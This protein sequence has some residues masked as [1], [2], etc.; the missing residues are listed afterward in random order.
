MVDILD[1]KVA[2]K[3]AGKALAYHRKMR[4]FSQS[5][6]GEKVGVT[7]QQLQKY[8]SGTNRITAGKLKVIAR[9]L[10]VPITV[11]FEPSDDVVD[12]PRYVAE[13]TRQMVMLPENRRRAV[14]QLVET[15]L[16]E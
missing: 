13:L 2:D 12:V 9:E 7:F 5:E 6:L 14:C 15:M 11:F 16:E 8:E 4:G 3:Y 1:A 10:N